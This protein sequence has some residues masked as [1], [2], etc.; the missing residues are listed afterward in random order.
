MRRVLRFIGYFF[1]GIFALVGLLFVLLVSGTVAVLH[2]VADLHGPVEVPKQAWLTAD[3]S[4]GVTE[5]GTAGPWQAY[6][7]RQASLADFVFGL[8]RAAQDPR[9]HGL[10]VRVGSG[11]IGMGQAQEI[12]D[13]VLQFRAAHKPAYAFAE[14]IAPG[15]NGHVQYYVASAFDKVF[16]APSGSLGLT[17]FAVEQ[18]FLRNLLDKL[19]I[20]PQ[21]DGR[22]NFKGALFSLTAN[23]MPQA[24]RDNLTQ[25]VQDWLGQTRDGII[26]QRPGVKDHWEE[27][28]RQAPLSAG[29]AKDFGLVDSLAYRD[30]ALA[31]FLGTL[32]LNRRD[33]VALSDYQDQAQQEGNAPRVG[34]LTIDGAISSGESD[35]S[36]A[37]KAGSDT[38]VV[39]IDE[40]VRDHVKALIVRVDSPGGSYIAADTMRRALEHAREQGVPVVIS[41]GDVAASGGY[42]LAL[43][44]DYIFADPGALVGSIGV[45]GGKIVLAGLWDKVGLTVEGVGAGARALME[46]PNR[47]YSPEEWQA[48]EQSLDRIYAD[49]TGH[50]AA[51]RRLAPADVD[52]L[53]GGQVFSGQ[54]AQHLG[55]IDGVGGLQS[56]VDHVK[57]MIGLPPEQRIALVDYPSSR[58]RWSALFSS[59][60]RRVRSDAGTDLLSAAMTR[61]EE[62]AE[63][64]RMPDYFFTLSGQR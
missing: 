22:K 37:R 7:S 35:P 16:L 19:G 6:F 3:L 14:D 61:L 36:G 57:Q 2:N 50:V 52:K 28:L 27:S 15:N 24:V 33:Q 59:A 32:H 63:V 40:A 49:F 55:L 53:A 39:A 12:R 45:F 42:F 43:P 44:A 11:H 4:E 30:Q 62:Q 10:F 13:A 9:I 38:I 56:A 54:R 47:R 46:S 34:L 20:E 58:A 18:P 21:M 26:A 31:D 5:V 60:L 41:M 51:Q 17:G 8:R 64:M 25:L 29:Q 23:A 48:F 1:V